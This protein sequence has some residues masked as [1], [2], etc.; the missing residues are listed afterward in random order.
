MP[1]SRRGLLLGASAYTLWGVLPLYWTLLEPA[2]AVELLAHRI[3]WSL[4]TMLLVLVLARR[5]D[6]PRFTRVE[7]YSPR[8]V[9]H[10]F[11][12]TAPDDVDDEFAAWV[13]EAYRV[14]RQE[15]LNRAGRTGPV[16]ET[17]P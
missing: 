15:H 10:A 4:G 8:N 5:V 2:G 12:L 17:S 16:R 1:D 13:G 6:S 11:R 3:L 9:L 7:T 14:G